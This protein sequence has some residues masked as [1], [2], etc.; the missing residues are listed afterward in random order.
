MHF[1]TLKTSCGIFNVVH[2]IIRSHV[3]R[4]HDDITREVKSVNM[5]RPNILTPTV[6]VNSLNM[7]S[8]RSGDVLWY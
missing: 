3:I 6:T 8:C 7:A 4:V 1:S 2:D 5:C